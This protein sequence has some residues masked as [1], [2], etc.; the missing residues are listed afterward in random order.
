MAIDREAITEK[1]LRTGEALPAY[2]FV[3]PGTGNYGEPAYVSWKDTPY[4]ERLA[5]AKELLAQAGFGPDHPLKLHPLPHLRDPQEGGDRGRRHVEAARRRDRAVQQRGQGALQRPAG[6]RFQVARAAWIADYNDA[7]NFLYLMDSSTGVLNYAGCTSPDFDRPMAEASRTA[8]LAARRSA[9]PGRGGAD[10]GHFAQY[11]DLLL[12]VE[13]SGRAVRQGAGSTTP[14][15]STARA[16]SASRRG[17]EQ[18]RARAPGRHPIPRA[19]PW[20]PTSPAAFSRASPR[21]SGDRHRGV[22]R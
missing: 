6:E 7:Q 11:S 2:S 15:T 17:A 19:G 22:L 9:P 3:P 20:A 1:V 13:G 14:R 18:A 4:P 5:E 8:D 12:R 16:G 21:A 10:G